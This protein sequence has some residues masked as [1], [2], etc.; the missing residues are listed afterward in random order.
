VLL[1]RGNLC[2]FARDD[3]AQD[4]WHRA[5]CATTVCDQRA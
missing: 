2:A 5:H 3:S 1:A 4:V